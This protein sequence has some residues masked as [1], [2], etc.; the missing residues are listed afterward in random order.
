M[1]LFFPDFRKRLRSVSFFLA[2]ALWLGLLAAACSDDDPIDPV[3]TAGI[4]IVN[5]PA[6]LDDAL[7]NSIAG[8]TIEIRGEFSSTTYSMARGYV[9]PASR[10]PLRIVGSDRTTFR[11][12]VV[13]PDNVDGLTFEGHSGSEIE[14]LDFRGG[15][16]AI[17]LN[18]SN[19]MISGVTIRDCDED[20][21]MASGSGSN[22]L[23]ETSLFE[24]PGRFG[25]STYAGAELVIDNNTIIEAGDCGLFL[26]SNAVVTN[27]NIV[28]ASV[29]GIICSG[30]STPTFNCNNAH[31][32]GSINYNCGDLVNTENNYQLDPEFCE[33]GYFLKAQ[34]PLTPA[35]S[36][37][38]GLIGAFM[39]VECDIEVQG[40]GPGL[41]IY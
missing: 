37:G 5:T 32:S 34:S 6:E 19:L 8:D 39:P 17:V 35:N 20:G 26:E 33:G 3:E 23:V 13:F 30:G 25:V 31:D 36:G 18:N 1:P 22:G 11:P 27:N 29:Y 4:I 28:R 2:P 9:I 10:S 41:A 24:R 38:C 21:V 12:E 16:N 15:N 7:L 40:A 14:G